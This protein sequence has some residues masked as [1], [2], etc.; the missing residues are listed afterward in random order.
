LSGINLIL[1]LTVSLFFILNFSSSSS[2]LFLRRVYLSGITLIFFTLNSSSSSILSVLLFVY[3]PG[4][5]LISTVSLF[6]TKNLSSLY[7]ELVLTVYLSG[8]ILI[9]ILSLFF[10]VNSSSSSISSIFLFFNSLDL[11]FFFV[12]LGCI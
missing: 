12:G 4:I 1:I 5:N 9:V 2:E 11:V 6:F 10:T 8:L 3:L 7:S